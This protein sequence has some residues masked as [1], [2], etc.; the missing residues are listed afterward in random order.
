MGN[1]IGKNLKKYDN[2]SLISVNIGN[3]VVLGEDSFIKECTLGDRCSIERRN[4]LFN[5]CIDTYTYTGYNTVIKYAD[6]G[7]FCSI[8]WNVSIGGANHEIT[9]LSTHPFPFLSKF[10]LTENTE[11]YNSFDTN[12]K[13]GNDVWIGAHALIPAA[14]D[15]TIGNGAIVAAG[16]VVSKDV[17][18]FAVVAGSPARVV[19]MRFSDKICADLEASSWWDYDWQEAAAALPGLAGIAPLNDAK[20]FCAWWRDGG[21]DMMKPYLIIPQKRRVRREGQ[22]VFLDK[23][24]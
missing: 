10:G 9:H 4:M 1:I 2:V 5:S 16:S 19:K 13:V 14:H 3:D 23:L 15:I 17:P 11:K 24:L 8:S 12:L 18:A 6:I 21:A 22:E 20:A 7:K